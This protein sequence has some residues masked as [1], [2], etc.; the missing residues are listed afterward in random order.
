MNRS[1]FLSP[2]A[3]ARLSP[4]VKLLSLAL[5]L[6]WLL[7]FLAIGY[8]WTMVG[9]S[10]DALSY[11]WMADALS[12]GVSSPEAAFGSHLL[13]HGRLPPGYP[14][15]LSA[16]GAGVDAEGMWRANL[17][18]IAAVLAMAG[19]LCAYVWKR[20][21]SGLV[22]LL[23]AM[24]VLAHPMITPWSFELFSEPLY[25]GLLLAVCL[26]AANEQLPRAW[27]WAALLLGVACLVRSMGLVLIPALV[28]WLARQSWPRAVLAGIVAATP[29]LIWS[30]LKGPPGEGT[31][32]SYLAQLQMQLAGAG[33]QWLE[34]VLT[35]AASLIRS[36]APGALPES[37]RLLL[38]SVLL[39]LF[40]HLAWRERRSPTLETLFVLATLAI[41]AIWP[42]PGYLD[43]LSGPVVPLL[44][45]AVIGTAGSGHAEEVARNS[46]IG[47]IGGSALV[48]M[49]SMLM[50]LAKLGQ[51]SIRNAE[52]ELQPF[53]RNASVLDAEDPTFVAQVHLASSLAARG[54]SD[55]VPAGQCVS[56]TFGYWVRL[57]SPVP[58]K[59]TVDPF[60]WRDNPCRFIFLI[61]LASPRDGFSGIYPMPLPPEQY[62][63]VFVSRETPEKPMLAAMIERPN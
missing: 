15:Y 49:L 38:G 8:P 5:I 41:L 27:L 16:F 17:A 39:L 4:A 2:A 48:I 11:L 34:F 50:T 33:G 45:V 29:T 24:Y 1:D 52:A 9:S 59:N 57:F 63:L 46:R 19:L 23:A 40:F 26:V 6:A 20:T 3:I 31:G 13:F 36:V 35:Q 14:I 51:P 12:H 25:T 32:A 37:L 18:Q 7:V 56:T 42:F 58:V 53:S 60:S 62:S 61:N 47:W 55:Q 21:S 43:R 44:L 30:L 54:L 22:V 28:W 10:F